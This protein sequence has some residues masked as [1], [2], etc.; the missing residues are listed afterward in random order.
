MN[1]IY[2]SGVSPSFSLS[3]TS[4]LLNYMV[5]FVINLKLEKPT[6]LQVPYSDIPMKK[7]PIYEKYLSPKA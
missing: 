4:G 3:S 5:I 6:Q 7:I 2:Y 1:V